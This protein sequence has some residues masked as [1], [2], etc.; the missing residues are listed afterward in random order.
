MTEALVLVDSP[1]PG[2]SV[3]T[4]NRPESL[5][6]LNPALVM[7]LTEQLDRLHGDSTTRVVVLTGAGRAFCAGADLSGER[8][9]VDVDGD[10]DRYWNVVQARYSA[11]VLKLRRIPQI[12]VAAVNGPCAGGGFSIA[13]A[14]DVRLMHVSGYFL[15]AQ[16]NIGQAISEMGASYLLPR[17]VGGCAAEIL[18]TGR[19]VQSE[20]AA[21]IG[22]VTSVASGSVLDDA[23]VTAETIASKAPLALRLSKESLDLSAGAGSL[24]SAILA[25]D[26][27]QVLGVLSAD[28]A[29]GQRAFMEKRPPKFST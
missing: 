9:P 8:F 17:I 12:V 20:E 13:M 27:A 3:L 23:L 11:L 21:R 26:R 29:E 2:V 14:S 6:A 19:R 16:I 22:L 18:L 7:A 24:E 28:L 1:S 15:G 4:L 25:E 10:G 5:N